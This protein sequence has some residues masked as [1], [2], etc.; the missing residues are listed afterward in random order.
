MAKLDRRVQRTRQS[1][2]GALISLILEKGYDA[3]TVQDITNRGDMRRATFYLHYRDKDD[4]L[5]H[6]LT[7][8]YDDLVSQIETLSAQNQHDGKAK[9]LILAAFRHAEENGDL[10]RV[11][12]SGQGAV[13]VEKRIKEYI[14]AYIARQIEPPPTGC[15]P[16]VP[17]EVVANYVAG[18]LL[19]L[20]LWWL[21][22][23]RPYPAE[24]MAELAC[25]M[26]MAGLVEVRE[27][28][29]AEPGSSRLA[30]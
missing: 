27:G 19:S 17:V 1:L 24:Y 14:A 16:P 20:I 29:T 25:R 12:L 6:T 5:F 2:R 11:I 30:G 8:I 3:V 21:E 13:I 10:Y 9:A 4:L 18:A 26:S 7:G 28:N 22:G 15:E 23:N